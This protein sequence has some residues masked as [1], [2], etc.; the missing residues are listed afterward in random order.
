MGTTNAEI[1]DLFLARI[2][3]YKILSLYQTS[4]SSVT[5]TY[6]EPFLLDA[7]DQ[8]DVCDQSLAYTTS[9]SSTDGYFTE[10]LTS[11]NKNVLSKIMVLSWLAKTIQQTL[12]MQNFVT[13]RDFKTFSAAQ[14]LQ[15]KKEY[16]LV[17]VEEISQLLENYA[18]KRTNWASWNNQSFI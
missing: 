15:A 14:N 2:D 7:I 3:D 18:L 1:T 12:Q 5:G 17:K 6:L 8:F 13:D 4:G 16:Y 10:I 9:G 11:E